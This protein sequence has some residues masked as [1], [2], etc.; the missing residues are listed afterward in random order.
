MAIQAVS[1]QKWQYNTAKFAF[2]ELAIRILR[3]TGRGNQ[4]QCY[5]PC[6]AT[7]GWPD[8]IQPPGFI[9]DR[10]ASLY[11]HKTHYNKLD[12]F[13]PAEWSSINRE[14]GKIVVSCVIQPHC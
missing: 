9:F 3:P 7:R 12:T 10:T 11:A 14:A 1:F 2:Q 4:Q 13:H 5:Q 6:C 8:T